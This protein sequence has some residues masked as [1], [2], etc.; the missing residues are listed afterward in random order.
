LHANGKPGLRIE[1]MTP[2]G[3]FTLTNHIIE[4]G[5]PGSS[6]ARLR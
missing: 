3:K 1:A 5:R 2:R 4:E 6:F